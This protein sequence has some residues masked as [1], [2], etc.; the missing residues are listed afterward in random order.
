M[1]TFSC[2]DSY[3]DD[4][5]LSA[6]AETFADR[7]NRLLQKKNGGNQSE[8]ARAVGV[9]PQA[10]QQWS[11]GETAPRGKRLSQVAEFLGVAPAELQFGTFGNI[12]P[13]PIG[14][15]RIPILSYVQAGAM[16]EAVAPHSFGDDAEYLLTDLDLSG[17][18]FALR[19][20][21]E[22]MAPDFQP[23]DVVII[24][25]AISPRPGDFVVA[26]NGSDEACFK[27]YRPRGI[28]TGGTEV[29][30]LVPLNEDYPSVRSDVTPVMIVGTMVEHRRYRRR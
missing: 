27:K 11:A 4:L 17:T 19:I 28:G 7:L 22:S 26:K 1:S 18:A 2:S 25:P 23:G 15:R 20:K 12:E 6:M 13:V 5:Y 3:K 14:G 21:G 29:F 8:L 30:E 10:V 9:S 24:D 16:T